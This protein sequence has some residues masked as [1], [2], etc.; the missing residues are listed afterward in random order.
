MKRIKWKCINCSDCIIYNKMKIYCKYIQ[1][2]LNISK[3]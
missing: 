3:K 1:N 2:K